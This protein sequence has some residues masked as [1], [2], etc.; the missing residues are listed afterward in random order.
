MDVHSII[1]LKATDI[2]CTVKRGNSSIHLAVLINSLFFSKSSFIE[3]VTATAKSDAS[4]STTK[5]EN[6]NI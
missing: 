2:V 3:V 6:G 1:G 4:V 5:G